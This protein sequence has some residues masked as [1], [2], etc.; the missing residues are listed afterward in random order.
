MKSKG[1][2]ERLIQLVKIH[3]IDFMALQK[4]F[5]DANSIDAFKIRLGLDHCITNKRNKV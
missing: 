2:F 4:P 1:A 3:K 5:L